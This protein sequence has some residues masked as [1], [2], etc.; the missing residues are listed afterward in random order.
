[1]KSNVGRR[2]E[3]IL[4]RKLEAEQLVGQIDAISANFD[5]KDIILLGDT[6]CKER[7]EDAIQAFIDGGFEDLN[8]DDIPTYY[9]G[10]N[11]PFDRIFIPSSEDRKAFR[12]SR[13]YILRSASPLAHDKYLSDHYMIKT[14]IVVRR[15]DE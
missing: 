11:A 15:D 6:N 13:Q 10:N 12:F 3:V 9:K 5:E 8:E 14:S 7:R 1:M 4:K 2:Q